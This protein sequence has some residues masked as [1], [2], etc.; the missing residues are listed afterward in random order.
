MNIKPEARMFGP[1]AFKLLRQYAEEFSEDPEVKKNI[2]E[3]LIHTD[4][5]FYKEIDPYYQ[6]RKKAEEKVEG[7][8][9]ELDSLNPQK[10]TGSNPDGY[11]PETYLG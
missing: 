10:S 6:R 8:Q 2:H 9:K 11:I 7:A 5:R 4:R 1:Q 3:F